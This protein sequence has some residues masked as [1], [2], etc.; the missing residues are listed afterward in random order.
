MLIFYIGFLVILENVF[1]RWPLGQKRHYGQKSH[2]DTTVKVIPPFSPAE[3]EEGEIITKKS[4]KEE[5]EMKMAE[6]EEKIDEEKDEDKDWMKSLAER[7]EEEQRRRGV[8]NDDIVEEEE[9]EKEDEGEE[10]KEVIPDEEDTILYPSLGVI[11]DWDK[12]ALEE[13][14]SVEE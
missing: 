2:I 4:K 10:G 8:N 9:Q 3:L 6:E 1:R 14:T 13:R 12:H 5:K 7:V 11:R